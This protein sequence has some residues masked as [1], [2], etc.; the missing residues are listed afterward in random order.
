MDKVTNK[1]INRTN[2]RQLYLQAVTIADIC[3]ACGTRFDPFFLE[4]QTSL[5]SSTTNWVTNQ[6][7]VSRCTGMEDMA[8]CQANMESPT[9]HPLPTPWTMATSWQLSATDLGFLQRPT[10]PLPLHP[11]NRRFPTIP[12]QHKWQIHEGH[13]YFLG[14]Q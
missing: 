7:T 3:T 9:G 14:T 4:G 5:L 13:T 12:G 10:I 11:K 6:S 2:N 8:P 1:E